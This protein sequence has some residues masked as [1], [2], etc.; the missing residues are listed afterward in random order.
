MRG[1]KRGSR[2]KLRVRQVEISSSGPGDGVTGPGRSIPLTLYA[3]PDARTEP[4]RVVVD[5]AVEQDFASVQSLEN[6]QVNCVGKKL[7]VLP[8]LSLIYRPT[9][10][11]SSKEREK[12]RKE[13][14]TIA[15]VT[16]SIDK[17]APELEILK[18]NKMA[19]DES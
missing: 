8:P 2:R 15:N 10:S 4:L 7:A 17:N 3:I 6:G 11:K 18:G 13:I 19:V 5:N 14:E 9:P 12:K 1:G 16:F